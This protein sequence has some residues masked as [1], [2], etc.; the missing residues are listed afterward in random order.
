MTRRVVAALVCVIVSSTFVVAQGA[1]PRRDGNW[2]VTIQMEMAGMPQGMPPTTVMQCVTKEEASDPT[3]MMPQGPGGRGGMPPECKVSD[4]KTE[5]NKMSWSMKCEGQNAMTGTGDVIYAGD[6]YSGT[7][8]MN[9]EAGGQPMAMT[10]K[11]TG[12]RM[13]DCTK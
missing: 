6:T 5:G 10:M 13:G 2:Q 4:L 9:V 3:K 8:K 12:K 11:Y 1:G 7:M